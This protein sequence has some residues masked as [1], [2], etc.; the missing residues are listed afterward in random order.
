VIRFKNKQL[1]MD[2]GYIK[3]TTGKGEREELDT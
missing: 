3:V 1:F 2:V